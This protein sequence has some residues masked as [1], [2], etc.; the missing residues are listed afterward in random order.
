MTWHGHHHS[1]QRTCPV[2]RERCVGYDASGAARGPVHLVIGGWPA[3]RAGRHGCWAVPAARCLNWCPPARLRAAPLHRRHLLPGL[4]P[5]PPLTVPPHPP[6]PV[7][8]GHAG[9]GLTP[10]IHFFR[11]RVFQSVQL[12]H[13]YVRVRGLAGCAAAR[14]PALRRCRC[15]SAA[16]VDTASAP[17]AACC[18]LPAACCLLPAACCLFPLSRCLLP[19]ACCLLPA[20]CCLL[21]AACCLLPAACF[22]CRAAGWLS[23]GLPVIALLPPRRWRQTPPTSPTG[24]SLHT[25]APSWTPS[26][27]PSRPAGA[28]SR[29]AP[30]PASPPPAPALPAAACACR[31]S[32]RVLPRPEQL[33]SL[34][35]MPVSCSVRCPVQQPVCPAC[36][37]TP[38]L[39]AVE[40][41]TPAPPCSR[42]ASLRLYLSLLCP[43]PNCCTCSSFHAP[44]RY[45]STS[46]ANQLLQIKTLTG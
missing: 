12:K 41:R 27:S 25:M 15:Y 21:P 40:R 7:P 28:S 11:P 18:L 6:L 36:A 8:A 22:R 38:C 35:A 20:A 19:A 45:N 26:P 1:Y 39:P 13:G 16:G 23:S 10:N 31:A 14:C 30:A 17:P 34:Y 4:G 29:A 42:P 3:C 32:R 5:H 46:H 2:Y 43:A 9:A 33:A 24:C 44:T 37:L